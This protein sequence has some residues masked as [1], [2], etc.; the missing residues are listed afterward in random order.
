M[1]SKV[2]VFPY[3]ATDYEKTVGK[4]HILVNSSYKVRQGG[5]GSVWAPNVIVQGAKMKCLPPL[6]QGFVVEGV[7]IKVV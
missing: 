6:L 4:H 5:K 2:Y 3:E 7:N 1:A